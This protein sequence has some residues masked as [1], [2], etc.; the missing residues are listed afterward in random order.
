M[1]YRLLQVI[2][3][4]G[5]ACSVLRR[6][7]LTREDLWPV[8]VVD[9]IVQERTS[10]IEQTLDPEGAPVV[11]RGKWV[12]GRCVCERCNAGWMST[13]ETATKPV[14]QPMITDSVSVL[15]YGKRWATALWTMKTAMVFECVKGAGNVS[16]QGSRDVFTHPPTDIVYLLGA[17]HLP[18][19]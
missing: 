1:I 18:I 19:R 14:L 17:C 9:L 5:R 7:A 6:R 16:A 15:D 2:V 11:Y 13:L 12:K 3:C 8:W 4:Q 10:R